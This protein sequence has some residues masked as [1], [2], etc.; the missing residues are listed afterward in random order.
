MACAALCTGAEP[1]PLSFNRDIRPILSDN[2]F[3][4]HGPIKQKSGLRLDL[5]EDALAGGESGE[6]IKPGKPDESELIRRV[7]SEDPDEI[8]PPADSKRKLSQQQKSILRQWIA[9]GAE[10]KQHW[11]FVRPSRPTAP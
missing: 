5:K 7:L 4:C 2:C 9:D 11:A 10:W 8:M 6:V 1:H 3:K